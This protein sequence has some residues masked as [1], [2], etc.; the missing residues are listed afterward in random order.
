MMIICE[1]GRTPVERYIHPPPLAAKKKWLAKSSRNLLDRPLSARDHSCGARARRRRT[2][3][4]NAAEILVLVTLTDERRSNGVYGAQP[5]G[6]AGAL[7]RGRSEAAAR[8][9]TP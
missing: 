4:R 8:V 5:A 6:S 1:R 2:G 9:R 3:S 7:P